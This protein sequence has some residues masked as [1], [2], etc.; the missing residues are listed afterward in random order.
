MLEGTTVKDIRL[1]TAYA[2]NP[3]NE[4]DWMIEVGDF[5]RNVSKAGLMWSAKPR[6]CLR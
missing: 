5:V 6:W 3:H 4:Y 2:R 1:V